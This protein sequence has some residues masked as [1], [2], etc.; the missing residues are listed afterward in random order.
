MRRTETPLQRSCCEDDSEPP[1]TC[2]LLI[3]VR[4]SDL[5]V[6]QSGEAKKVLHHAAYPTYAISVRSKF[7]PL[8]VY[9]AIYPSMDELEKQIR[10]SL[11]LAEYYKADAEK[12]TN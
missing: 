1:R 11:D 4:Y 5:D 2:Q 3:H 10:E 8:E 9:R 6:S 7:G 12:P